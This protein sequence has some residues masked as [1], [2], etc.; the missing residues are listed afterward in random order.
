MRNGLLTQALAAVASTHV[1]KKIDPKYWTP[2][3]G[4]DGAVDA[5]M[6]DVALNAVTRSGVGLNS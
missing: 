3:L 4:F 1:D 5:A 2:E 6:L